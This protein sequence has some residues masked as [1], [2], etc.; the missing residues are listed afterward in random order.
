MTAVATHG[1]YERILHYLEDDFINAARISEAAAAANLTSP[2]RQKPVGEV[3]L[4]RRHERF[5]ANDD[6]SNH[7]ENK[8]R[9]MACTV[10]KHLKSGLDHVEL[11]PLGGTSPSLGM[12]SGIVCALLEALKQSMEFVISLS[13]SRI[14][15]R[16]PHYSKGPAD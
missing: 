13:A 12:P 9:E 2:W 10:G 7:V 15:V 16:I 11:S 3:D 6:S 14:M 5:A 8:L 1:S 4:L